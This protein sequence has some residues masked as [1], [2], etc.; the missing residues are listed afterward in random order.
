MSTTRELPI[1]PSEPAPDA[2][3]AL[4]PTGG[5]GRRAEVRAWLSERR[6]LLAAAAVVGLVAGGT[7]AWLDVRGGAAP[8]PSTPVELPATMTGLPALPADPLHG[9]TWQQKAAQAAAGRAWAARTYGHAGVARTIRV[10]VA[11]TDLT[12]KLE[13]AWAAGRGTPVGSDTCTH[14]TKVTP[15]SKARMRPT[16][17]ICWRTTPTLSAYALV[18]DPRATAPV[19]D[20]DGAAALDVAWRAAGGSA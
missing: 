9:T 18:V 2:Q 3:E 5:D 17:L 10:V 11:R 6:W 13:Q 7:A 1:E 19:P 8:T 16:V 12:G 14:D 4:G 20:A 15:T